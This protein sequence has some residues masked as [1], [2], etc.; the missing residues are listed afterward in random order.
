L[1]LGAEEGANFAPAAARAALRAGVSYAV[2][3]AAELVAAVRAVRLL[4]AAGS[5][6]MSDILAACASLP[7]PPPDRDLSADLDVAVALLPS[8]SHFFGE[9]R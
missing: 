1:S 6:R 7:A 5:G 3:I 2:I 9:R 4:D 8:L